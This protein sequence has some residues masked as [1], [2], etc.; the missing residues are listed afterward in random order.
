MCCRFMRRCATQTEGLAERRARIAEQARQQAE[1][2]RVELRQRRLSVVEERSRGYQQRVE[3]LEAELAAAREPPPP[4]PP[5]LPPR[6][7]GGDASA[8]H[9]LPPAAA[10]PRHGPR[11]SASEGSL[12]SDAGRR[13]RSGRQVT[14]AYS[15][16]ALRASLSTRSRI[17]SVGAAHA[18]SRL[19]VPTPPTDDSGALPAIHAHRHARPSDRLRE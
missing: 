2:V 9:A 17:G 8:S 5:P 11:R 10:P 6:G 4:P 15:S 1:C 13:A 16:G 3:A 19:L 18:L 14:A 12:L 7:G